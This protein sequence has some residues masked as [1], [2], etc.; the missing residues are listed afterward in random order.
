M[1]RM[2]SSMECWIQTCRRE[3]LD[4][5]SIW[6]QSHLLHALGEY[7][8]RSADATDSTEPSTST[9]MSLDQAG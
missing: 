2:N 9:N 3:L 6:N 5:T 7:T 4:Q 1:P 8:R